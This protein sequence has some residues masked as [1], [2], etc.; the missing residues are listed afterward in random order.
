MSDIGEVY[1]YVRANVAA[2][3]HDS[4][5]GHE[6][7]TP[8]LLWGGGADLPREFPVL[9]PAGASGSGSKLKLSPKKFAIPEVGGPATAYTN[10]AQNEFTPLAATTQKKVPGMRQVRTAKKAR[11]R[12]KRQI[13][14]AKDRTTVDR[15]PAYVE[16]SQA[17]AAPEG[18]AKSGEAKTADAATAPAEGSAKPKE[19][20]SGKSEAKPVA[21]GKTEPPAKPVAPQSPAELLADGWQLS[22]DLD[23]ATDDPRPVDYA[24]NIWR[25]YQQW[26]LAEEQLYR[27][28]ELTDSKELATTLQKTLARLK[29]LP[30]ISASEEDRSSDL[31]ARI[32]D[33][34]P[35]LPEGL[36]TP[37]SLAMAQ[38]FAARGGE[39]LAADE[40]AAALSLDRFSESGTSAEFAAW[41]AK[42][43]PALD[44]FTEIRW[45]RQLS[46]LPNLDWSVVQLAMTTR[47][48]S[49][50]ASCIDPQLLPWV[51]ARLANADRLQIA[52]ERLLTDSIDSNRQARATALFR[53]A[54]DQY[55]DAAEDSNQIA[56]A[57]HLCHDLFNR[58]PYYVAWRRN[59]GWNPARDAPTLDDLT[60]LL[61]TTGQLDTALKT[62]DP[63]KI[64]QVGKL[65]AQLAALADRVEAGF[66]DANLAALTGK[67]PAAGS[68]WR[69]ESLLSTPL[70]N[71]D[72]RARLLAAIAD[73][74]ARRV[75]SYHSPRMADVD[76]SLPAVGAKQWDAVIERAR[77][78]LAL[79]QLAAGDDPEGEKMAAP[80]EQSLAQLIAAHDRGSGEA[81][82]AAARKFG[83]TLADFF[84][85][86]PR[87]TETIMV[88][89]ADL[90]EP[91]LRTAKLK[92]IQNADRM[93][94][95]ID[96]RDTFTADNTP[97]TALSTITSRPA[98][99]WPWRRSMIFSLGNS[100]DWRRQ[101][102][103]HPPPTPN[104]SPTRPPA[105]DRGKDKSPWNRRPTRGRSFR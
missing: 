82:Y 19:P 27:A 22:D 45:A 64:E 37:H 90:T 50:L 38:L 60:E 1:R 35:R 96:V 87:R 23:A 84:H 100:G 71:A 17:E 104:S 20:E 41:I 69:I 14:A 85:G 86:L 72:T 42:A 66:D 51:Q 56:T 3:V 47:R 63:A 2:W 28:G 31:A 103:M 73:S 9:L 44:R 4:T 101:P 6:T 76:E 78:E 11:K 5:A 7:Q 75:A 43:A 36:G 81:L 92:A 59:S 15:G 30:N 34:R 46:K 98:V 29:S 91:V 13:S 40:Q 83:D 53:Q 32:Q 55:H 33:R 48:L 62:P 74:D 39:P 67:S 25:E 24:P 89:N 70:A 102:P 93:F 61:R 97:T 16:G 18:G 68:G 80:I 57:I 77:L 95:L 88:Q 94:R 21:G 10:R 99:R 105:I 65:A 49:E 26:L 79:V 12:V 54:A 8:V 52:A 58:A